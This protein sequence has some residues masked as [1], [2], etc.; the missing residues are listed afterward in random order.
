MP[1]KLCRNDI[2]ILGAASHS[3]HKHKSATHSYLLYQHTT[4]SCTVVTQ[5]TKF[6][7][8]A[9]H[10]RVQNGICS[11]VQC[12]AVHTT[13]IDMSTVS[14]KNVPPLTCYNLDIHD[15]TV[16]IFVR[17]VKEKAR[18]QTVL[19]FPTITY[20][21]LQHYLVKEETQN[22]AH[23]CYVHA[24]QSNCCSALDFL[25]PEPCP[26]KP[27][28]ECID[29]KSYW[30]I[31]QMSMS[32]E[33]KRLKKSSSDWLNSGN[34]LIQWVKMQFSCFPFCQVV[35]A[36]VIWSGIVKHLFI[37]CSLPGLRT[38]ST[39]LWLDRFFWASQFFVLVLFITIFFWSRA[40]D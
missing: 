9:L 37:A 8:S 35:Q 40:A 38:D 39:A 22:R 34:A 26:Q 7:N 32:R 17:N 36:Q 30:V 11:R 31:Q 13:A 3:A 19:C 29:Y 2:H 20:L 6:Q 23:W 10:I 33:S 25:S 21:V 28:A 15:P 24:T 1:E 12:P 5:M 14:Q 16:I 27:Q 4:A 18:N